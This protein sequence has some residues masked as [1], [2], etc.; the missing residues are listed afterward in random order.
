MQK[1]GSLAS[2]LLTAGNAVPARPGVVNPHYKSAS[3]STLSDMFVAKHAGRPQAPFSAQSHQAMYANFKTI[4]V[5]QHKTKVSKAITFK[6]C[7]VF[8]KD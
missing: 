1:Q 6:G 8:D 7:R 2:D 4:I 3:M 5:T